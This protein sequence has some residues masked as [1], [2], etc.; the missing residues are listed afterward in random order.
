[1]AHKTITLEDLGVKP[2]Q[3]KSDHLLTLDP[4]KEN[5]QQLFA[6]TE[7]WLSD[8]KFFKDELSFFR[9]LLSQYLVWI[10]DEKSIDSMR[11]LS[12]KIT[13]LETVRSSLDQR[14]ENHQKHLCNL[15]EN[16]F[17]HDG[18]KGKDEH[19]SL[20]IFFADFVKD[21]RTIKKEAFG[22]IENVIDVEK[23]RTNAI[24]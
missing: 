14:F 13:K 4:E 20:E 22:L 6:L 9:N 2:L 19:T 3:R 24:M 8:V 18:Q 11:R 12:S 17:S 16:P 15:I 7:H 21:F 23:E 1:M 10:N 5:W